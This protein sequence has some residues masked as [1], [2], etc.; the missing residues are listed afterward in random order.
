MTAPFSKTTPWTAP[1]P[2]GLEKTLQD[3]WD[4]KRDSQVKTFMRY[5]N[6]I[7]CLNFANTLKRAADDYVARVDAGNP[8][9]IITVYG[10]YK[11][12][13]AENKK[14]EAFKDGFLRRLGEDERDY[15]TKYLNERNI[16]ILR[17]GCYSTGC[18]EFADGSLGVISPVTGIQ[19]NKPLKDIHQIE[20]FYSYLKMLPPEKF[21]EFKACR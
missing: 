12:M 15:I 14:A 10:S 7:A 2:T 20:T 13:D 11:I 8:P 9:D 16:V 6:K 4:G 5:D 1:E 3:I 21:A 18:L 17:R 19:A